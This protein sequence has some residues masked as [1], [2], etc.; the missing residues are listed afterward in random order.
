M[1]KWIVSIVVLGIASLAFGQAE[2]P[3]SF[4]A[5]AVNSG[6]LPRAMAVADF[7][8]DGHLDFATANYGSSPHDVSVWLGDSLGNWKDEPDSQFYFDFPNGG[9]FGIAAADFNHDGHPDLAVTLADANMIEIL[10]WRG[11]GFERWAEIPLQSPANPRDIVAADFDRDGNMDIAY[12][13]YERGA[14]EVAFGEYQ[15]R[16][17]SRFDD[18]T[19]IGRG[20]HGLAAG[21]VLPSG[22]LQLVATNALRNTVCSLVSVAPGRFSGCAGDNVFPVGASPRRVVIADFNRDGAPDIAVVNT[23]SNS[24]TIYYQNADPSASESPVF[25]RRLDVPVGSS[26]RDLAAIDADGDGAMDLA[27]ASYGTNQI[28]VLRNDGDG[29]F[30]KIGFTGTSHYNPRTLGIA[31]FSEDGRPDILVGNQGNGT[32]VLWKNQTVFFARP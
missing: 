10:A 7:N 16:T 21:N 17:W 20:A 26:P 8:G 30:S 15:G 23:E 31:D 22:R 4:T 6:G 3:L 5:D 24:V 27:V 12:T 28:I 29:R 13:L 11:V 14:V 25:V 19:E 2:N 32:V 1:R 9:P 18:A